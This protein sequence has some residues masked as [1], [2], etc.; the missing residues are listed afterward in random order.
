MV[1]G[2]REAAWPLIRQDLHLQYV[3]IGVILGLPSIVSSLIEP[4]FG[5]LSDSGRRRHVIVAGGIA[6]ALG[7][8]LF[9][10][11]PAF[12]PLLAAATILY[13]ASGAFVSL[14]QTVLMDARPAAR[15]RNMVRWT[16]AGA[17]GALAGPLLLAGCI[18][19]GLGWRPLF[20]V[21][22]ILFI[23]ATALVAPH[24]G[25]SATA[26][27]AALRNG[28]RDALHALCRTDVLRWLALLECAD[29]LLDVL[30][31]YLGLY[32]VDVVGVPPALGAAAV[33]VWTGAG[34][35]GTLGALP[36]LS[37]LDGLRYV[38]ISALAA[39]ALFPAMLLAPGY[40]VKVVMVGAL[41]VINAGWYP[42][43]QARL[44]DALPERSGTVMAAG[45]IF[46]TASPL[47]PFVIGLLAQWIGL[48][49]ALWLLILGPAALVV[50][51]PR[52]GT[53]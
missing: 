43:L 47:L 27:E 30:F 9:A 17:V 53:P 6:F 32:F 46:G 12:V 24:A 52:K 41:A 37:R 42:T 48:G 22:A 11:S 44:Y 38:R 16:A 23:P 51:V 45:T 28:L 13:P 4:V 39:L 33:I 7:L 19:L 35:L 36:L 50:A 26:S 15:E 29:L 8:V 3:Q 20:F 2:T 40:G 31:G 49:H 1:Y 5:V 18:A 34:L 21:C 25:K 10:V 14:S